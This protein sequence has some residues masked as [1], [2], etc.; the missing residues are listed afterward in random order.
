LRKIAQTAARVSQHNVIG[1]ERKQDSN[2]V[3]PPPGLV[4]TEI[5]RERIRNA[6][7]DTCSASLMSDTKWRKFISV[8]KKFP[9]IDHYLM[10]FIRGKREQVC[11]GSLGLYPPH[12]FID[13]FVFGPIYLREIEWMELPSFVAKREFGRTPPGG[14][15]QDIDGFRRALD[16]VGQFPLEETARGL[17]VIGH[18]RM[19]RPTTRHRP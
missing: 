10:K 11:Y 19:T 4:L 8:L 17:R 13:T 2:M 3:M 18:R 6:I 5:E 1:F 15:H 7:R 14:H 9:S 12:A 16:S